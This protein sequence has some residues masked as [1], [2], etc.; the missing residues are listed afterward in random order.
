[1]ATQEKKVRKSYTPI[2]YLLE[3]GIIKLEELHNLYRSQGAQKTAEFYNISTGTLYSVL[4]QHGIS[5]GGNRTV[6]SKLDSSTKKAVV[7]D[8]GCSTAKDVAKK[9]GLSYQSVCKLA[10]EHGVRLHRAVPWDASEAAQLI[11]ELSKSSVEKV[12]A[13]HGYPV[14][15]LEKLAKVAGLQVA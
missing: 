12:A 13:K 3:R 1:M 8:L 10:K 9:H 5:D 6:L 7:N 4:K 11:T 14:N 15:K 2:A